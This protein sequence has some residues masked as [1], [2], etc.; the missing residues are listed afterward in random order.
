M[1]TKC[2]SERE[3]IHAF[4]WKNPR[5][6][7]AGPEGCDV[8]TGAVLIR[9]GQAIARQRAIDE[10]G[11]DRFEGVIVETRTL[12][13][14]RTNIRQEHV[15]LSDEFFQNFYAFGFGRVDHDGL[16]AAIVEVENRIV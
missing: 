15:R 14:T 1:I 3:G 8:E 11:V 2:G 5:K 6:T 9:T 4:R 13:A 10:G 16:L 7:C 12:K